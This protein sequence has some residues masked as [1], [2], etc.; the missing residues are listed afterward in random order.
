MA[1]KNFPPSSTVSMPFFFL[2]PAS[3][4]SVCPTPLRVP[5]LCKKVLG[6]VTPVLGYEQLSNQ[7]KYGS[8][9]KTRLRVTTTTTTNGEQAP[10][11]NRAKRNT[12]ST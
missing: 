10:T 6:N 1:L 8:L 4:V 2:F 12:S 11:Q 9:S 7:A 3:I 5:R